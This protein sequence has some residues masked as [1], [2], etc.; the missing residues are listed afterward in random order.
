MTTIYWILILSK[1]LT[2]FTIILIISIIFSIVGIIC[3]IV[4][5]TRAEICQ[6]YGP[7]KSLS[8]VEEQNLNT[9]KVGKLFMKIFIPIVSISS[10]I[11]I[12]V[13]TTKQMF[14]IIVA[15]TVYDY[16]KNNGDLS[17]I[18]DKSI[19]LLNKTIDY[20]D[21]KLEQSIESLKE[22]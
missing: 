18:P 17:V 20:M 16:A 4:S 21:I 22:K 10:L 19:E 15:G 1:I 12:F 9:L 3:Y 2:F 14:G 13:P 7:S 6:E 5:N 11:L 8:Y